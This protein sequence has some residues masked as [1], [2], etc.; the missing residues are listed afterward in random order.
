MYFKPCSAYARRHLQNKLNCG[1]GVGE[2]NKGQETGSKRGGKSMGVRKRGGRKWDPKGGA[3]LYFYKKK[4]HKEA[5]TRV[6]SK[7]YRKREDE[8]PIPHLHCNKMCSST[9]LMAVHNVKCHL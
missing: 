6:G 7:M 3:T 5:R 8:T 4:K 1:G 2:E 9:T